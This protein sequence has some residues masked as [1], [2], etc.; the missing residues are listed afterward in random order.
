MNAPDPNTDPEREPEVGVFDVGSLGAKTARGL[1]TAS[2]HGFHGPTPNPAAAV[3]NV[4]DPECIKL[5][6][7]TGA[8]RTVF[9]SNCDYGEKTSQ[10]EV[11]NFRTA[12]GEIVPSAGGILVT[13]M[14]EDIRRL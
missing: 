7:D 11:L 12:T 4:Q 9:P 10:N 5:N 14:S 2:E 3:S 8:A 13:G 6:L 1:V